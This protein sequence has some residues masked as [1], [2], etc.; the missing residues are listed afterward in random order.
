M[1]RNI[2]LDAAVLKLTEAWSDVL[3]PK[4]TDG[5]YR[6][7]EH[8]ALLDMLSE[9]VRSSTGTGAGGRHATGDRI[10]N[11]HAFGMLENI[12]GQTRTWIQELSRTPADKDLK[13]AVKQLG[14]AIMVAW[15][16]RQID[17]L[18][19]ERLT[20][21]VIGWTHAIWELFDPPVTKEIL[22]PCPQCGERAYENRDGD[23]SAAVL[24]SYRKG[25]GPSAECRRCGG[26]WK[27]E[28]ELLWLGRSVNAT[29]DEDVL[30]EMGLM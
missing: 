23:R 30:R 5:Q 17:E 1:E 9:A 7:I 15:S 6:H 26:Q 22:A 13:G 11:V 19:Y 25:E 24:A 16:T 10:I 27:G 12:D 28:K 14:E 21:K 8:D 20:R 2:D 18:K 3:A 4:I 29:M